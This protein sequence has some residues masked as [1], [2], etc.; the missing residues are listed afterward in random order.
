MVRVM[1]NP[2]RRNGKEDNV[3]SRYALASAG[4]AVKDSSAS[5]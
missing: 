1:L 3:A 4:V 2:A 5:S